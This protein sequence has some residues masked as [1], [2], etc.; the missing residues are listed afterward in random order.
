M[1]LFLSLIPTWMIFYKSLSFNHP[2]NNW[3]LKKPLSLLIFCLFFLSGCQRN[4]FP[5]YNKKICTPPAQALDSDTESYVSYQVG[6]TWDRLTLEDPKDFPLQVLQLFRTGAGQ[7]GTGVYLGKFAGR[8]IVMTASHV[9]EDLQ[10]CYNEVNFLVR[11]RALRF[12]VTCSDWH[13]KFEDND[14]MLF[15]ITTENEEHLNLFKPVDFSSTHQKGEALN[16]VSVSSDY[17]YN[18]SWSIDDQKDCQLLS[19]HEKTLE[20]PDCGVPQSKPISSWSL[21]VGCDGKHGDSGAP[22]YDKDFRLKGVLWTGKFPKLNSSTE[23]LQADMEAESS[24]LWKEYNYIVPI[25][26][27]EREMD[28]LLANKF[29]LNSVSREVMQALSEKIKADRTKDFLQLGSL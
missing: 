2:T 22:V 4:I 15:S 24:D 7:A 18:F 29:H 5:S 1:K 16:L 8:H 27:L 17:D 25:S 13:H 12:Y 14:I 11:H 26:S 20:D 9:Y 28:D 21:P 6:D 3:G 10:S 19:T 23:R